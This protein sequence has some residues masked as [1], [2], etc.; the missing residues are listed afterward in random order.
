MA[1]VS[2]MRE[3]LASKPLAGERMLVPIA[4]LPYLMW[5]LKDNKSMLVT[6]EH[7]TVNNDTSRPEWILD[8][9]EI[10]A[11]PKTRDYVAQLVQTGGYQVWLTNGT[12]ALLSLHHPPAGGG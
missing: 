10:Y 1:F 12:A 2:S 7:A 9:P 3:T 5:E 11:N 4:F 6:A 8:V